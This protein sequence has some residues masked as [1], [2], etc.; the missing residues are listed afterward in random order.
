LRWQRVYRAFKSKLFRYGI[1]SKMTAFA[2]SVKQNSLILPILIA[3]VLYS[4][5]LFAAPIKS[6]S[7]QGL[8]GRKAVLLVDGK[9][10]VV[11]LGD[12]TPEGVKLVAIHGDTVVMEV[13]GRK[14]RQTMG[15]NPTFSTQYVVP[16]LREVLV[17]QNANGLF[18]TVG[19]INGFA[20][21]LVVDTGANIVTLNAQQARRLGI[22]F[23]EQGKPTIVAT[24]SG[25]VKAYRVTLRS[26][27][28][29]EIELQ[30]VAAVVINGS[31]PA[32]ILLG[33]TFL[34]SL[35]IQRSGN[36]MK[37]SKHY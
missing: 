26:V 22:D 7:I 15:D 13:N 8:L 28:V 36:V 14:R 2:N 3:A 21:N 37:I 16:R 20:V 19:S 4:P 32:Q 33:M 30:N 11:K 6:I 29:G 5:S 1:K 9:R 17:T 24:A 23:E 34:G 12:S 35:E 10:R 25:V 18:T 31:S 27:T